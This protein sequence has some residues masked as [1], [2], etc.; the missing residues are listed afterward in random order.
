MQP[1]RDGTV[2]SDLVQL[3]FVDFKAVG[4]AFND[5]LRDQRYDVCEMA[6]VAFMQAFERGSPVRMLPL[7]AL[8]GFLH[9]SLYYNPARGPLS[10]H[11]LA[12]KR[13][14]VRSYSQTTG[15]WLRGALVEQF[16]LNLDTVT[17]VTTDEAHVEGF[18]DPPNVHNL[19]TREQIGDLLMAG[20][21]DAGILHP[22]QRAAAEL[23][24]L[25]AASDKATSDWFN[26]YRIVPVNHVVCVAPSVW[27]EPRLLA[28]VG[29][30]FTNSYRVAGVADPIDR[31]P[32]SYDRSYVLKAIEVASDLAL[33]QRLI[34]SPFNATDAVLAF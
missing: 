16:G 18:N 26:R 12:H 6:L 33:R 8:G 11:D 19:G 17:W 34:R 24:P 21:V 13:I 14:G 10:P 30:M 1:L 7:V 22:T 3:D 29:T 32:I 25:L 20:K 2:S 9:G 28:E 15:V 5:M 23:Q 27:Q 4:A 31:D